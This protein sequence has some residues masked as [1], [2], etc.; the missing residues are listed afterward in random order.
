[1]RCAFSIR[2]PPCRAGSTRRRPVQPRRRRQAS[3]PWPRSRR[4]TRWSEATGPP[5][6]RSR[7]TTAR[8]RSPTRSA[9]SRAGSA[10]HDREAGRRLC[11]RGTPP[12]TA[13][14]RW[15]RARGLLDRAAGDS[16]PGAPGVDRVCRGTP[17][18][19][20]RDLAR[21][22]RARGRD[23]EKRNHAGAAGARPRAAGR[24]AAGAGTSGRRAGRVR[25]GARPRT[26]PV[27][28]ARRRGARRR[29]GRRQRESEEVLRRAVGGLREGG[30]TCSSRARRGASLD[31]RPPAR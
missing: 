12:D 31:A 21:G 20:A 5:P 16:A 25:D 27:P 1:M 10:R 23:R 4:A 29:E 8:R 30:R 11:R 3:S 15:P 19:S 26:E 2:W 28:L 6:R 13:A 9:T 14:T 18:R 24:D 22:R 7:R 17:R